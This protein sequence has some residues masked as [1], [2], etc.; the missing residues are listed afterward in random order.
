M[1]KTNVGLV[2]YAKKQVGKPYWFGCF[3]N[4]ATKELLAVKRKQYPSY[5]RSNDFSKQLGVKVHDCIGL[6]KGYLWCSEP[7]GTPKYNS[8]QDVNAKTMY[9][10]SKTKGSIKTVKLQD[11]ILLFKGSSPSNI[12]HVGIYCTD[13]YVYEAK[14]H[15]WGVVK[16]KYKSSEWQYWCKCIYIDYTSDT[17]KYNVDEIVDMVIAGKL[18]NGDERKKRVQQLGYDYDTIQK[19]VNKKLK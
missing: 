16:T 8:K 5:Y 6:I 19:L 17:K 11:G 15:A 7:N 12:H 2:E 1:R 13:G 18:G 10:I 9:A 4:I 3:G 14:G